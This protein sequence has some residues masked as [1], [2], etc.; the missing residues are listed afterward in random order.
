MPKKTSRTVSGAGDEVDTSHDNDSITLPELAGKIDNYLVRKIDRI[1]EILER[2]ARLETR[3]SEVSEGNVSLRSRVEELEHKIDDCEAA[4]RSTH[5]ILSG[6]EVSQLTPLTDLKG[7]VIDLLRSSLNYV[8]PQSDVL[9]IHR[10]G[11][12][13]TDRHI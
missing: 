11:K 1:E 8:V 9:A 6:N 10:I 3:F 2:V 7:P 12:K 13:N 5:V 4:K